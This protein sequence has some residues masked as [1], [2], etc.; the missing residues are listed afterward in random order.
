MSPWN[1]A[2]TAPFPSLISTQKS[3]LMTNSFQVNYHELVGSQI[4]ILII[5]Y[6]GSLIG[7]SL[8]HF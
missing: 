8:A 7:S 1:G 2:G 6:G 5:S 4:N 3:H